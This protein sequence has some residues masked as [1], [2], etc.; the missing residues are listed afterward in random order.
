MDF[1]IILLGKYPPH[2]LYYYI[3]ILLIILLD[4]YPPHLLYYYIIILL[5][6]LLH[7]YPPHLLYYYIIIL[8]DKYTS[9]LFSSCLSMLS[10]PCSVLM[11]TCPAF[12]YR[13]YHGIEQQGLRPTVADLK[14]KSAS[15]TPIASPLPLSVV[16]S[17]FFTLL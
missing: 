7:K 11:S 9:H 16:S 5:I 10:T 2:L 4:K 14:S 6:I 15:S 12:C 17:T 1:R 3:I 8:L 13:L